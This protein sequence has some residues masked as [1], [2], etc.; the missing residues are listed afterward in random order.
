MKKN[1][2]N[3]NPKDIQG[4]V[5][6]K[7]IKSQQTQKQELVSLEYI[8]QENKIK[9][10]CKLEPFGGNY[11][12]SLLIINQS[13]APITEIKIRI[14][15]PD[16]F[17]LSRSNPPKII[18]DSDLIEEN[19]KQIR[20]EF[21][22]ID[23]NSQKQI[24]T[25]FTPLSL[26][27]KGE[28]RSYVTFIN[29]ADFV[30]ALDSDP[31][32]VKF[33]PIS[34]E[35]KILPSSDVRNFLQLPDIKRGIKSVGIGIEKVNDF[36]YLFYLLN[37]T[38]EDH[39]FQLITKDNEKKISWYFGTELVS[40]ADLLIIGQLKSNKIE[41]LVASKN[42]HILISIL[43]TFVTEFSNRLIIENIVDTLDQIYDLECKYCGTVL[44]YFPKKG[45]SVE[46][47]KCKYEK[48]IWS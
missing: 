34:I 26:E 23:Q 47:T 37:Q 19:E 21:E 3:K 14:R 12:Y 20:I 44:P 8:D 41:V 27:E 18:I 5:V 10:V 28:I 31:I 32:A 40:G 4:L 29:N 30:R 25:F 45:E 7:D 15:Y 17:I 36:D 35:K 2:D 43:T 11:L 13:M 39:N 22:K 9:L 33:D 16:F 46:C 38:I 48:I 42:P 6:F 24:N 1:P